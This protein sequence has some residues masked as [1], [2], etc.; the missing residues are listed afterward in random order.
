LITDEENESYVP[1]IQFDEEDK[2]LIKPLYPG[3]KVT[4]YTA[5]TILI[6]LLHRLS[7]PFNNINLLLAVLEAF[8]PP[9][10]SLPRSKYMFTK[11]FN[12]TLCDMDRYYMC[13][14]CKTS[15]KRSS[16]STSKCNSEKCLCGANLKD[17]FLYKDPYEVLMKQASNDEF[18]DKCQYFRTM[19]MPTD[20][21]I[22]DICSSSAYN[23]IMGGISKI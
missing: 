17:Y 5:V 8:L 13:T 21:I 14:K 12:N 6:F 1:H 22:D 16:S 20:G 3:S 23:K 19:Y 9:G 2:D 18:W 10:S 4:L 11:Y 7:L 15:I